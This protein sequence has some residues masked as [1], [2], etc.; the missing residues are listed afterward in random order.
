MSNLSFETIAADVQDAAE[1]LNDPL[2][3]VHEIKSLLR[4]V[5]SC[6]LVLEV[7]GYDV[8]M[9]RRAIYIEDRKDERVKD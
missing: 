5:A 7:A 3:N 2:S 9:H 8:D 1:H 6:R 4:L